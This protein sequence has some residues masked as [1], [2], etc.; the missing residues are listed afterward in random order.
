MMQIVGM[1]N[2]TLLGTVAGSSILFEFPDATVNNMGETD[3]LAGTLSSLSTRNTVTK[4]QSTQM[5]IISTFVLNGTADI[6]QK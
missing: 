5:N 6:S 2:Q 1:E 4:R 3:D